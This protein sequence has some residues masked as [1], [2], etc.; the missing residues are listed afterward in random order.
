MNLAVAIRNKR[1]VAICKRPVYIYR[2]RANSSI[3]TNKCDFDFCQKLCDIADAI[4]EGHLPEREELIGSISSRMYYYRKILIDNDY[5]GDKNHP[6]VKS[7]VK[8]MNQ[9]KV[10]RLTDR[11]ILGVSNRI[12][13]KCCVMLSNFIRLIKHPSLILKGF[14]KL[15]GKILMM[16]KTVTHMNQ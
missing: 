3:H 9:A 6:F 12:S 2:F 11:L 8:K 1:D 13:V 7:I 15:I 14:R 16:A 4:V 5:Q 10:L